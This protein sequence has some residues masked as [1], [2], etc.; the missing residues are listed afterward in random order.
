M[1]LYHINIRTESHIAECIDVERDDLT[2]L[3]LEMARFVGELLR[4]H[5]EQIWVDEDWRVDVTD[6]NGAIIYVM[7]IGANEVG[8]KGEE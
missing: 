5:A 8:K 1:A 6:A 3:R 7:H 2:G 4:D